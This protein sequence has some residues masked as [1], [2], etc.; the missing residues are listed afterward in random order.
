M[1][2]RETSAAVSRA[3]SDH[4]MV[5]SSWV[6]LR[7]EAN[8]ADSIASGMSGKFKCEGCLEAASA[9]LLVLPDQG[10]MSNRQ[11]GVGYFV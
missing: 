5:P 10:T 8:S 4:G 7:V 11:A 9:A 1:W 3:M 2:P 6:S